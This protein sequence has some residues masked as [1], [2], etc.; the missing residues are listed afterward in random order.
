MDAS[1]LHRGKSYKEDSSIASSAAS[2]R[3]LRL[4]GSDIGEVTTLYMSYRLAR[5]AS[6]ELSKLYFACTV[7][8]ERRV[9]MEYGEATPASIVP[10]TWYLPLRAAV[11]DHTSAVMLYMK[12]N[13]RVT[14]ERMLYSAM[15]DAVMLA[16][17]LYE[18]SVSPVMRPSTLYGITYGATTLVLRSYSAEKA[19][20]KGSEK[21]PERVTEK[22]AEK[23][24]SAP[25]ADE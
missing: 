16:S 13:A 24:T 10:R 17:M 14:D 4:Y 15:E 11:T 9:R 18:T 3:V 19:A 25:A 1:S 23:E 20:D 6:I 7:V 8:G 21:A 5:T 2:T 22:A 12:S